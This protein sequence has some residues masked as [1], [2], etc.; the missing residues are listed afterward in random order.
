MEGEGKGEELTP[1]GGRRAAQD[2]ETNQKRPRAGRGD[3]DYIRLWSLRWSFRL[4]PA[5]AAAAACCCLPACRRPTAD[6][7][8]HC[9][10]AALL[11][12]SC[13]YQPRH[14]PTQYLTADKTGRWVPCSN[15]QHHLVCCPLRLPCCLPPAPEQLPPLSA[16][17][18]A[19]ELCIYAVLCIRNSPP[20]PRCRYA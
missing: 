1:G 6:A 10:L 7:R 15:Q 2:G 19:R 12:A 20:Q 9:Q 5:A 14:V 18:A 16:K 8:C 4:L 3:D 11:H 17:R 13:R